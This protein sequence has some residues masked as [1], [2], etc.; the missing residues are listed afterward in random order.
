[1]NTDPRVDD[2]LAAAAEWARPILTELRARVHRACPGVVET[3]KWRR[4]AFELGGLIGGMSEFKEYCSFGFWQEKALLEA[5]DEAE[6]VIEACGK[7]TTLKQLPGKAAFA[8]VLKLALQRNQAG[9]KLPRSKAK[10]H[11]PLEVPADLAA[12]L[13]R[14]EAAKEH[15]DAFAPSYRRDYIEW[16]T[17]AKKDATRQTRIAQ[18]VEWLRD[19]KKR[20]W[21]YESC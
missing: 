2:Y 12:A 14:D 1:M 20:H 18:A 13:A 15:F 7:I 5:G 10:R 3:I 4:P 17:G 21:K 9:G 11:P 19:G 8:R 6:A 16:I